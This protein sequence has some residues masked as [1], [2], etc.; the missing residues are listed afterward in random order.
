MVIIDFRQ[1]PRETFGPNNFS[2]QSIKRL[3]Q[4]LSNYD[5]FD[6]DTCFRAFEECKTVE[7]LKDMS[8]R[9]MQNRELFVMVEHYLIFMVY[10]FNTHNVPP[11]RVSKYYAHPYILARLHA[12]RFNKMLNKLQ[13]QVKCQN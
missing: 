4:D 5:P 10:Y 2:Q 11:E 3:L 6:I 9:Q 7:Q 8:Q 13:D 1:I 12:K